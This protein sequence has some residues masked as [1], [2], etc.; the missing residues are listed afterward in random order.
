VNKLRYV[1]LEGRE[2]RIGKLKNLCNVLARKFKRPDNFGA[3]YVGV[4]DNCK[5]DLEI[6]CDIHFRHG[7]IR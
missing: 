5:L 3:M 4:G 6:R 7:R 1:R 2:A